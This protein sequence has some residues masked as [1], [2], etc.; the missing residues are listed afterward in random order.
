MQIK[1]KFILTCYFGLLLGLSRNTQPNPTQPNPI[2]GSGWVFYK[3]G[4]GRV[5][6]SPGL[7]W[8]G[9]GIFFLIWVTAGWVVNPLGYPNPQPTASLA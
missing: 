7:S 9:L 6:F 4:L 5:G 3:I 2:Q 8:G 1:R